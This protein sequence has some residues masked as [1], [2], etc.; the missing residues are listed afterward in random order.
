VSGLQNRIVGNIGRKGSGKST[1]LADMLQTLDR[2]IVFDPL[3]EHDWTPNELSSMDALREFFRWNKKR[4]MWAANYV[5]GENLE[6]DLEELSRLVYERGDCSIAIEEI[7]LIATPGHMPDGF[8]KLVRTGRHRKVDVYWTAQRAAEVPRTLTS[9]TDEFIFFSQ[10]E[11]RDLDAIA[12]RCGK[13]IADRV[14]N[15]GEHEH[16]TYD[17]VKRSVVT[18]AAASESEVEKREAEREKESKPI[19]EPRIRLIQ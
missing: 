13:E 10:T 3:A 19:A 5:P 7:P 17:V 1:V 15:L 16:F 2:P 6:A 12:A 18:D 4:A 9:L 8:G 11:P 14:M